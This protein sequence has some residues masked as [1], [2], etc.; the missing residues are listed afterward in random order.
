MVAMP[1][2][3]NFTHCI[4]C[5][6]PFTIKNVHTQE[7]AR[8]TQISSLCEDCFDKITLGLEDEDAVCGESK[9]GK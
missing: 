3:S 9:D 6:E 8:E 2:K 4:N 7:G 5:K 1:G